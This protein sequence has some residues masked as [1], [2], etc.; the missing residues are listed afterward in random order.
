MNGTHSWYRF[1]QNV[2]CA[3]NL[4][5]FISLLTFIESTHRV[6]NILL[7]VVCLLFFSC[8]FERETCSKTKANERCSLYSCMLWVCLC[9]N[10]SMGTVGKEDCCRLWLRDF[11]FSSSLSDVMLTMSDGGTGYYAICFV[12]FSYYLS[13]S[14]YL[15][16]DG[17]S[18]GW[19]AFG[20]C[21]CVFTPRQRREEI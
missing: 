13:L 21:V 5:R 6:L 19:F 4:P 17:N 9:M 3:P 7:C 16:L 1:M 2:C 15:R 10:A 14:L 8:H 12:P 11:P 18:N 20:L